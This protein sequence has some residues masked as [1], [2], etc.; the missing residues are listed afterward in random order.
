MFKVKN[1]KKKKSIRNRLV[2]A[3]YERIRRNNKKKLLSNTKTLCKTLRRCNPGEDLWSTTKYVID[4]STLAY[5]FFQ[6]TLLYIYT[7]I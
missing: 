4:N 7:K 5:I 1:P 2:N 6:L 3:F